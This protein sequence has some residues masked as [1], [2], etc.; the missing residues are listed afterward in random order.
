MEFNATFTKRLLFTTSVRNGCIDQTWCI[1][2]CKL[3]LAEQH[4]SEMIFTNKDTISIFFTTLNGENFVLIF[5]KKRIIVNFVDNFDQTITSFIK[6]FLYYVCN[7]NTAIDLGWK[8]YSYF[9][10]LKDIFN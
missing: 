5:V 2:T 6:T 7:T 1:S 3:F 10:L 8:K 9:S 4:H